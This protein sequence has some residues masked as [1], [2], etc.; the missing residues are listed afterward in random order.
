MNIV[1][2]G[3]QKR[4][5]LQRRALLGGLAT[6]AAFSRPGLASAN[7]T[8]ELSLLNL[9]TG[10]RLKAAFFDGGAYVPEALAAFDKVLRDHR[11]GDVHPMAPSLLDLVAT[12]QTRLAISETVQV[13]S[14][15]R[16]P[17]SNAKLAEASHGVATKSLHM[18]GQAL[19]IRIPSV[20]L[21]RLRDAA[22]VLQAGGVG[23]YAASNFV[24]VD[25]GRV[26]RW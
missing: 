2:P 10:E 14:G 13:I 8:R 11:T 7:T 12:L 3:V 4:M 18:Q 9:H 1:E 16:S 22:L 17:T 5:S 20:P 15:Y 6:T 25:I 21:P 23:Y 19:D 24:H 26:R